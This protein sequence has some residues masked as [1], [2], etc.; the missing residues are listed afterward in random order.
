M[1]VKLAARNLRRYLRRTLLTLAGIAFGMALAMIAIGLGD[2]AHDMMIENGLQLGQGHIT[3]QPENYLQSP[4]AGLFLS[5]ISGL[6]D[7]LASE[8]EVEFSYPRIRGEGMLSSAS[9]GEGISFMGIDPG[10]EG[11]GKLVQRSMDSGAFLDGPEGNWIVVGRKLAEL[12]SLDVG[13]KTVLT[14]QDSKGQITSTLLRVKGIF[15]SGSPEIDRTY[16]LIPIKTAQKILGMGSG[17]TSIAVYLK[18]QRKTKAVLKKLRESIPSGEIAILPWQK[19]QP[20]LRDFVVLDDAFG[21]LY[22][23]I[24]LIIVSIGVLN[25]VLMSVMNRKREIGILMAL[26]MKPGSVLRMIL[27]ET[28]LIAVLGTAAGLVIGYSVHYYFATHGLDLSSYMG[29]FSLAGTILDPVYYSRLRPARIIQIC[30]VIILMTVTMGIYPAVKAA[31]TEPV[32][33][34]EKP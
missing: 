6:L 11:E 33:A 21:Y 20:S 2:G 17:V 5:N 29:E 13:R 28:C 22:Y 24:I 16:T 3:I 18:E 27:A 31:R 30:T 10:I 26:G 15:Y 19:V 8:P 1:I 32:E 12:L 7:I 25:T 9:G 34:M 14:L 23:L 4:S